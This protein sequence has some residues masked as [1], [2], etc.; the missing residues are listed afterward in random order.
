MS[1]FQ[2]LPM[3]KPPSRMSKDGSLIPK[4]DNPI[5][6]LRSG[7]MPALPA[8]LS[9]ATSIDSQ[10]TCHQTIFILAAAV[11]LTTSITS[12]YRGGCWAER[13]RQSIDKEPRAS[14]IISAA[15]SASHIFPTRI[16]FSSL[17]DITVTIFITSHHIASHR[18]TSHHIPKIWIRVT[19]YRATSCASDV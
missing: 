17:E 6:W 12:S 14:S 9:A 1:L 19:Q 8:F 16:L 3:M 4:R 2:S 7:T 11:P 18:I 5:S 10:D 15:A 13:R